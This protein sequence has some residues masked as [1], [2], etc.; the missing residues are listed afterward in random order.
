MYKCT[1]PKLPKHSRRELIQQSWND[2]YFLHATTLYHTCTH[3]YTCIRSRAVAHVILQTSENLSTYQLADDVVLG[4]RVHSL[5]S[6]AVY[7]LLKLL[8]TLQGGAGDTHDGRDPRVTGLVVQL[9]DLLPVK[10][11]H[12]MSLLGWYPV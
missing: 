2:V 3:V 5:D 4:V 6:S 12:L 7:S 9:L 10:L 1:W 8:D 11:F